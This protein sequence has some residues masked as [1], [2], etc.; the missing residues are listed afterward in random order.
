MPLT[1]KETIRVLGAVGHGGGLLLA[2][3][4]ERSLD[5]RSA[6]SSCRE[7][8][9]VQVEPGCEEDQD[10][11]RGGGHDERGAGLP[12]DRTGQGELR[13]CRLPTP[14]PGEVRCGPCAP[15]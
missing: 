9:A 10:R 7:G 4:N 11:C 3:R 6:S 1:R 15:G 2:W 8:R 14:G 12:G 13:R 5:S